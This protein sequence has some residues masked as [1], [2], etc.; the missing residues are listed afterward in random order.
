MTPRFDNSSNND[1]SSQ[2]VVNS[3]Y[4]AKQDDSDEDVQSSNS[5]FK[6][7]VVNNLKDSDNYYRFI[8]NCKLFLV[9]I[10]RDREWFYNEK[11]YKQLKTA[12]NKINK[13]IWLDF[14]QS[15]QN[16][17]ESK[18]IIILEIENSILL[19]S[20]KMLADWEEPLLSVTTSNPK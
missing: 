4:E 1:N 6:N 11:N 13:H 18:K 17:D 5:G 15:F 19:A 7:I 2:Q 3:D 14:E 12:Q 20:K 10:Q 9:K 8:H 16:N